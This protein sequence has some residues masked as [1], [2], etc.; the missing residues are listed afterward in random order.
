VDKLSR[1]S[2]PRILS[3]CRRQAIAIIILPEIMPLSFHVLL[4]PQFT[5]RFNASFKCLMLSFILFDAYQFI[6]LIHIYIRLLAV[7][8]TPASFHST[9]S[10][11]SQFHRPRVSAVPSNSFF[12]TFSIALDSRQLQWAFNLPGLRAAASRAK[13]E[14]NM[15]LDTGTSSHV[16]YCKWKHA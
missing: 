14:L 3:I 15:H 8:Q 4:L 5:Q 2:E 12:S 6:F 13:E 10:A 16:H 7:D 9:Q 1:Q 11:Q